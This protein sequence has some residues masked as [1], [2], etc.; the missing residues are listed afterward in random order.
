MIGADVKEFEET[1]GNV[2]GVFPM[3]QQEDAAG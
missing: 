2:P 3:Y 1:V